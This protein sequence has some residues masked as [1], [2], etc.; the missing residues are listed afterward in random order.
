MRGV[1]QDATVDEVLAHYECEISDMCQRMSDDFLEFIKNFQTLH[2]KN[3]TC[4]SSR[5]TKK[6]Y[7]NI[8]C[9]KCEALSRLTEGKPTTFKLEYGDRENEEFKLTR[10]IIQTNP[11]DKGI[12]RNVRKNNNMIDISLYTFE[13]MVVLQYIL[14]RFYF[15]RQ[16]KRLFFVH[17]MFLRYLSDFQ[18]LLR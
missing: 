7:R 16:D 18:Q 17:Q 1:E 8:R 13:H 12:V 2:G 15:C 6:L 3:N 4:L 5:N 10:Y 14:S 9:V 11:D